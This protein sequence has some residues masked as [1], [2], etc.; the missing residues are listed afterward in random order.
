M[1]LTGTLTHTHIKSSVTAGG[2][3]NGELIRL[4]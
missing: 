2:Q 4:A 3:G 1:V